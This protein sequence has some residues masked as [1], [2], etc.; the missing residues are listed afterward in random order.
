MLKRI[1]TA[2]LV[3]VGVLGFVSVVG[4]WTTAI[5][6]EFLVYGQSSGGSGGDGGTTPTTTAVNII[7]QVAAGS[8]DGGAN[9]FTTIIQVINSSSTS[10][11]LT[12]E[13]FDTVG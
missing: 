8:F 4:N 6:A 13:F 3:A 2:T 11:S 9:S 10:A 12:V 5:D 7:P 1:L